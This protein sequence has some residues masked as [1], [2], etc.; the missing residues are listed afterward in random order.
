MRL[1]EVVCNSKLIPAYV[2]FIAILLGIVSVSSNNWTVDQQRNFTS[3][4]LCSN[5]G[6]TCEGKETDS[7]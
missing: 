2:L 7:I 5:N 4:I 6:I 1:V 3:G